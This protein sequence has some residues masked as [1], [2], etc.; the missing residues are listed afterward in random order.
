MS[1]GEGGVSECGRVRGRD[2]IGRRV[3]DRVCTCEMLRKKETGRE[4]AKNSA[5]KSV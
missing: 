4:R 3:N 1:G 2:V 5:K